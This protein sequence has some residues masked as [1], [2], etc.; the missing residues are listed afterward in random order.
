MN[1][2]NLTRTLEI[3][4]HIKKKI[5]RFD[6]KT[7]KYLEKYT[8]DKLK[9][10]D[11]IVI[12]GT[13]R[14]ENITNNTEYQIPYDK[15]IKLNFNP[16]INFSDVIFETYDKVNTENFF[17]SNEN[18]E[19]FVKKLG[20]YIDW[21]NKLKPNIY[22]DYTFFISNDNEEN[23]NN[24]NN[25]NELQLNNA[26]KFE[27]IT[28]NLEL[29]K[30]FCLIWKLIENL[31]DQICFAT[32]SEI[33]ELDDIKSYVINKNINKNFN[34]FKNEINWLIIIMLGIKDIYDECDETRQILSIGQIEIMLEKYFF[35]LDFISSKLMY[36]VS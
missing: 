34:N 3:T 2:N 13:S 11:K 10:S 21:V 15:P 20:E 19:L 26:S 18:I 6:I 32:K 23:D 22:Q 8:S 35:I 28:F 31:Y 1:K 30:Y 27:I 14:G 33:N 25:K 24:I 29:K 4:K 16:T 17:T 5:M 36:I 7:K 12:T 9:P